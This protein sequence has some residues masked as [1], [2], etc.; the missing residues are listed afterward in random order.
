[1]DPNIPNALLPKLSEADLRRIK[2]LEADVETMEKGFREND[3]A[4]NQLLSELLG[5]IK[6]GLLEGIEYA[7]A[8]DGAMKLKLVP[9]MSPYVKSQVGLLVGTEIG[10]GYIEKV[11]NLMAE[12]CV[13]EPWNSPKTWEEI[14]FKSGVVPAIL[15]GAVSAIVDNQKRVSR[16]RNVKA[17]A[18][19]DSGNG[20]VQAYPE[21]DRPT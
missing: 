8:K 6:G 3:A 7:P 9:F 20:N 5:E 11:Y 16:F 10:P 2:E 18:D 19:A 21:G 13:E 1:M 12:I 4:N 15:T 14:Q 17:R